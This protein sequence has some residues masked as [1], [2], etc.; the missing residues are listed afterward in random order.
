[1]RHLP[2]ADIDGS[3]LTRWLVVTARAGL[4]GSLLGGAVLHIRWPQQPNAIA[5]TLSD[6]VLVDGGA[7]IFAATVLCLAVGSAAVL[8]GLA[9]AGASTGSAAASLLATWCAA[10]VLVAVFPTDP[11]G[12]A[13]SVW[14]LVHRYTTGSA[15]VALPA[16]GLLIARRLDTMPNWRAISRRLRRIARASAA[17]SLTFLAAHLCAVYPAAGWTQPIAEVLG[18]AERVTVALDIG[19]LFVLA[20]TARPG[21][22]RR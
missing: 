10:L 5:Q 20:E 15:L 14:G 3:D 2:A 4:A 18:L 6:Y 19:L 7:P 13:A 22:T 11:P 21:R 9:S 16:A 8:A 1:M 12:G 17:A